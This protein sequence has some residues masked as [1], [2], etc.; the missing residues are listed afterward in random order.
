MP[1]TVAQPLADT[2]SK[3]AP[4]VVRCDALD[5]GV[6]DTFVAEQGMQLRW[7]ADGAAIPGSYWGEPE[8]GLQGDTLF[9]RADT[10]VHSALHELCHWRCM[11]DARRAVLHTDAG[12]EDNEESGVCY[13]QALLADTLP[14]YSRAQLFA[15]MDAWGYHFR[16]GSAQAWFEQDAEDAREWLLR[17]Q[18]INAAGLPTPCRRT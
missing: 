4:E 3:A 9:V 17:S 11:D 7:I 10:P 15:D 12:G 18:L 6:L 16:L 8:A 5:S 2:S 14:G 13:L 1:S